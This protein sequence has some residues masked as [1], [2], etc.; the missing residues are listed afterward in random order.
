MWLSTLLLLTELLKY[1][2]LK[3]IKIDI[4]SQEEG[5]M[6]ILT[7]KDGESILV[8]IDGKEVDIDF[9]VVKIRNEK[10]TIGI[11]AKAKYGVYRDAV[12]AKIK[13]ENRTE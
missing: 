6:L 4:V 10:V 3:S 2:M 5:T 7:I 1:T 11:E 9:R 8:T 12:W 13:A